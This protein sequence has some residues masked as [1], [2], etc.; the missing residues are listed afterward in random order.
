MIKFNIIKEINDRI[1]IKSENKQFRTKRQINEK[2]SIPSAI[3]KTS[4]N[5]L[6]KL[7]AKIQEMEKL[8]SSQ[9]QEINVRIKI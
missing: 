4:K 6:E 5:E 8:I 9:H 3:N 7:N 2:N 1:E